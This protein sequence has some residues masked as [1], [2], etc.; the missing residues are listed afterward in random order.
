MK[1]DGFKTDSP[2]TD[3][4]GVDGMDISYMDKQLDFFRDFVWQI[5]NEVMESLGAGN[6][7]YGNDENDMIGNQNKKLVKNKSKI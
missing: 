1:Q 2:L 6:M 3:G 4:G 5:E 7:V